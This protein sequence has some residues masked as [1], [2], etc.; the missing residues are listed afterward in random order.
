MGK[1]YQVYSGVRAA[2]Q[3]AGD[4]KVRIGQRAEWNLYDKQ[5]T[6]S[7]NGEGIP[8][9]HEILSRNAAGRLYDEWEQVERVLNDLECKLERMD[10]SA[11]DE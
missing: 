7:R 2:R 3:T 10:L 5:Q 6:M 11:E 4:I 1:K 9:T 8:C